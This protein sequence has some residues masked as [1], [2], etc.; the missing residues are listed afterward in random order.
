MMQ[1]TR[2]RSALCWER[3]TKPRCAPSPAPSRWWANAG[4]ADRP[5]RSVRRLHAVHRL[6]AQPRNR[7]Q[8]PQARLDGFVE[9]GIMERRQYSE[10]PELSEY[11]LTEKGRDLA[12]S[13]IALTEWGD[14][15]AAPDG[16]PI[17]YRHSAC[18]SPVTHEVVCATC[19]PVDDPAA[20]TALPGPGM[21]A[22]R[23]SASRSGRRLGLGHGHV[24]R[25]AGLALGDPPQLVD[26]LLQVEPA[27]DRPAHRRAVAAEPRRVELP[28]A[29]L[30]SVAAR[31]CGRA[32]SR[33]VIPLARS[34]PRRT[35][36]ASLRRPPGPAR[37][38]V[39]VRQPRMRDQ[40]RRA[41]HRRCRTRA[42]ARGRSGSWPAWPGRRRA[43]AGSGREGAG[44]PGRWRGPCDGPCW[45]P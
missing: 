16:P 1:A 24:Q 2:L 23:P 44:S 33:G 38:Q 7:D 43:T 8:H 30:G 10:Q 35:P 42:A 3:R 37:L 40:A 41:A 34:R 29:G 27:H 19:G 45:S 15:W 4:A 13:L 21:P 31:S 6:P 32:P 22:A 39:G 18:G 25:D 36:P 11:R 20:V 12:P 5:Q 14:R 17:L 9:A 28:A 26:P